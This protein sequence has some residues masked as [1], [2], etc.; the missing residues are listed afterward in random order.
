LPAARRLQTLIFHQRIPGKENA[1][2]RRAKLAVL[3]GIVVVVQNEF[4]LL[5]YG[6]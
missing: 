1:R 4:R 5:C 6:S 3:L 2:S